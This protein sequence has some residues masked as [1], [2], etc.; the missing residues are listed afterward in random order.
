MPLDEIASPL[1]WRLTRPSIAV[2]SIHPRKSCLGQNYL[3]R[4]PRNDTFKPGK[5]FDFPA[6]ML[7]ELIPT[8]RISAR[9]ACSMLPWLAWIRSYDP[10]APII[11]LR[12]CASK[13]GKKD[14]GRSQREPDPGLGRASS[15]ELPVHERSR[16]RVRETAVRL[17]GARA[18][19]VGAPAADVRTHRVSGAVSSAGLAMRRPRRPASVC[20]DDCQVRALAVC[21]RIG[22]RRLHF[23]RSGDRPTHRS[24]D[25]L[26]NF[27]GRDVFLVHPRSHSH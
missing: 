5:I 1:P 15:L 25:W 16:K 19:H 3:R 18:N 23:G 21:Y 14:S 12:T 4:I 9:F 20:N 11:A 2:P 27:D 22:D 10:S 24:S 17:T 8:M 26:R 6:F 13:P 7:D